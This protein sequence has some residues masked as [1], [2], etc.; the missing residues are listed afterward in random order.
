[1][2]KMQ[3]QLKSSK[4]SEDK[5]RTTEESLQKEVIGLKQKLDVQVKSFKESEDKVKVTE[6]SLQKEIVGLKQKLDSVETAAESASGTATMESAM[7]DNTAVSEK[8]PMAKDAEKKA[9]ATGAEA[10]QV[11]QK[12]NEKKETPSAELPP[13]VPTRT[14][15]TNAKAQPGAKVEAS[16]KVTD[17]LPKNGEPKQAGVGKK[18]GKKRKVSVS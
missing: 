2:Q 7:A 17:T 6:E 15:P 4:E 5:A 10:T 11:Q 16:E 3:A 14:I 18:K 8:P 1:M 9:I 13:P 12:V